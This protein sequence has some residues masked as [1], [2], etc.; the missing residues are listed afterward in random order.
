M[1]ADSKNA[2][3][4]RRAR[5]SSMFSTLLDT[6][7]CFFAHATV[8]FGP[9]FASLDGDHLGNDTTPEY[10][11]VNGLEYGLEPKARDS[12]KGTKL[13]ESL[14]TMLASSRCGR[15]PGSPTF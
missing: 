3:K 12:T 9:S 15:G 8:S 5:S 4:L 10:A 7:K 2:C 13:W 6:Y 1:A 14:D 11:I